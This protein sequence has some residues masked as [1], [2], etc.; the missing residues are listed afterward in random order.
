MRYIGIILP[1]PTV[2]S[3]GAT[4]DHRYAFRLAPY[5][6]ISRQRDDGRAL[7]RKAL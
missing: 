6:A 5:G 3:G 7:V 1:R 2:A 4:V